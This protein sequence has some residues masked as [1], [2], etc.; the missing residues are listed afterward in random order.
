MNSEIHTN[1]RN[2]SD[3]YQPLSHLTIYQKG[4]F[5]MGIKGYVFHLK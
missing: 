3:F 4:P 5:Y 2:N 1:T